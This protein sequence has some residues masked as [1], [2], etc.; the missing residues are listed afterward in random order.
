MPTGRLAVD[1][2]WTGATGSPGVNVWHIRFENASAPGGDQDAMVEAIRDFYVATR[3]SYPTA[4]NIRFNGEIHG[5]GDDAGNLYTADTWS[6][7]GSGINGFLPPAV[8][9]LVSWRTSSATRS[10]RGRTFIGPMSATILETNGTP[11]EGFR[12]GTQAAVDDLIETSDSFA[13]GA[14]GIYSRTENVFRD[15]VSGDVPNYF[16]VLRSRRD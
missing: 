3:G 7:T 4:V 5:V 13:N 11:D 9:T 8:C 15:L 2:S 1:L 16:A 12:A 10:G 14:V 6:T